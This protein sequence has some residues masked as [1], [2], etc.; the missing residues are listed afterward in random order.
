[1]SRSDMSDDDLCD[2]D[3]ED[4]YYYEDDDMVDAAVESQSSTDPEYFDY[5]VLTITD[6]ERL[7]NESVAQLQAEL[8]VS[9]DGVFN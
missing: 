3:N 9:L 5:Q 7:L 8:K 1:M 6:V 4:S 2:S